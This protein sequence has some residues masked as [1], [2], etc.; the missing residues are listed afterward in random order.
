MSTAIGFLRANPGLLVTTGLA[1]AMAAV[2]SL[3]A[4]LMA[5]AGSSLRPIVFL[6]GFMA[7]VVLPQVLFHAAQAFGWIPRRDTAGSSGVSAGAWSVRRDF[8]TVRDFGFT[9]PSQVFGDNFDADLVTDMRE[10]MPGGILAEAEAAQMAIIPPG[11]SVLIATFP[12]SADAAVAAEAYLRAMVGTVPP[13]AADGSFMVNRVNDVMKVLVIDGVL[14]AWSGPDQTAV[15][16]LS[17]SSPLLVPR[18]SGASSGPSNAAADS[19][20]NRPFVMPLILVALVIIASAWFFRMSTWASAVPA[21]P[22]VARSDLAALKQRLLAISALDVPFAVEPMPGDP[23]RLVATWRYADAR[24]I[25][26]ARARGLRRTYRVVLSF[27]ESAGVVRSV[28]QHAQYDWSAGIGGADL[29]W[30]SELGIIFFQVDRHRVFGLQLDATGRFTRATSYTWRFDVRE[31]KTPLIQAV[32]NA[33][34]EWRPT[35]FQGPFWLRW[36]TGG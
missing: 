27:D 34:W 7:I 21:E 15:E 8:L 31:V 2:L 10:R 35:M 28:D 19:W 6:G 25:D 30:R 32:T 5:R 36:L 13:L 18:V 29:A 17:A 16:Q 11:A 20:V 24:W 1:L 26:L 3:V 12:N 23:S 14:L 4:F 33:G 22:T 9:Q